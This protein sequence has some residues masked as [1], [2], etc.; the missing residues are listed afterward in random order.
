MKALEQNNKMQIKFQLVKIFKD[1]LGL[2]VVA[3]I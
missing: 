1:S 3:Y 2:G